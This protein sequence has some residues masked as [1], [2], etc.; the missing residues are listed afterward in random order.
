MAGHPLARGRSRA[1]PGVTVR[2]LVRS[3]IPRLATLL[4][5]LDPQLDH[6]SGHQLLDPSFYEEHVAFAGEDASIERRPVY[7]WVAE[8]EE[9]IVAFHHATYD[10][11]R[12]TLTGRLSTL[13]SNRAGAGVQALLP[14]WLS[15]AGCVLGVETLL[16]WADL[17]EPSAQLACELSGFCLFGFFPASDRITVA[18]GAV[19]HGFHA[20]YGVSL[21]P[22][23]QSHIPERSAMPPRVAALA[24]FVLGRAPA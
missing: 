18:P 16:C 3:D 21:V 24:D 7:A 1:P 6:E 10:P 11:E 12:S 9:E 2:A 15:L 13:A 17:R 14:R 5:E 8:R 4:R 20:V 22:P 19:R 23:E